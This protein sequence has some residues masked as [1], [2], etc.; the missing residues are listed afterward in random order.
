[1]QRLDSDVGRI[2]RVKRRVAA[3]TVI[4]DANVVV[5]LVREDVIEA[6]ERD[7]DDERFAA[8]EADDVSARRDA[9][10]DAA[11]R[12]A[13]PGSARRHERAVTASVIGVHNVL[14][15]HIGHDAAADACVEQAAFDFNVLPDFA[16]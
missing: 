8:A 7:R 11:R 4:D 5:E 9:A 13:R 15:K 3:P 2:V 10:L 1:M 16:R 14:D 12:R 6:C